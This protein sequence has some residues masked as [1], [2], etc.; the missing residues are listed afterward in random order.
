MGTKVNPTGFRL[1]QTRNWDSN[2]RT[3]NKLKFS[4]KFH[5]EL[6]IKELIST[7]R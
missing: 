5:L 7:L 6:Q 1:G 2:W 4:K 3:N